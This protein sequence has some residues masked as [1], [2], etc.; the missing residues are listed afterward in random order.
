[1]LYQSREKCKI[2][3]TITC[4]DE[5]TDIVDHPGL[6]HCDDAPK[7]ECGD[8]GG[9]KGLHSARCGGQKRHGGE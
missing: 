6:A 2:S 9:E 5:G 3:F 7:S 1:M 8:K 4:S